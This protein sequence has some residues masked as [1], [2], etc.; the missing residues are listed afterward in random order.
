MKKKT[1]V[2]ERGCGKKIRM[3]IYSQDGVSFHSETRCGWFFDGKRI[4]CPECG[5]RIKK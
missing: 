4:Y 3:T 2:T 1:T 5:R